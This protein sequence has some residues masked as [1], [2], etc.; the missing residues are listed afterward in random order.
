[1]YYSTSNVWLA[2]E[3]A[4]N[5]LDQ[6]IFFFYSKWSYE[7]GMKLVLSVI[8]SQQDLYL[9]CNKN[10]GFSFN[11]SIDYKLTVTQILLTENT[12][13]VHHYLTAHSWPNSFITHS[14]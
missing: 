14:G 11:I 8:Y 5:W 13:I 7:K 10:V 6:L 9:F 12:N 2:H 1:M 3:K 4:N